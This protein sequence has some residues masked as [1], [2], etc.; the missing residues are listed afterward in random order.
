MINYEL[1]TK[2]YTSASDRFKKGESGDN[3]HPYTLT[4]GKNLFCPIAIRY[5]LNN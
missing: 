3:T 1:T 2:K 5:L 4:A